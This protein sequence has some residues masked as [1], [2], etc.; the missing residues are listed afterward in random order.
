MGIAFF[1]N[2][3]FAV[4]ELVGGFWTNSMAIMSDA[5]HDFGDSLS[6]GA[7]WWLEKKSRQKSDA[8]FTYGYRRLSVMSALVTGI[9]LTSGS[10]WII[11]HALP[12]IWN[13]EPVKTDGMLG[14]AILGIVVNGAGF[15]RLSSGDSLNERMLRWHFI[16]DLS[17][18]VIVLIAATLMHFVDWP[19]IDPLLAVGLSV[20]VG[21]NVIRHLKESLRV[22]LQVSPVHLAK[23]E[24][25]SWIKAQAGVQGV[26]HAHVWS[27]DDQAHIMT[28]H[29]VV[30]ATADLAVLHDLK[31]RLKKGLREKFAILEA[32]IEFESA[33]E[34][35]VDPQHG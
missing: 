7:A 30:S 24:A 32:T 33:Q 10:L 3:S 15:L 13:P 23:G 31:A 26:H 9:V 11:G 29:V 6:L 19:W 2:L 4:I 12:R 18:W 20:W 34:D 5:L 17:G 28:A 22:F 8:A 21:W 35:C 25:E 14:L 16:E 1:L 27:L